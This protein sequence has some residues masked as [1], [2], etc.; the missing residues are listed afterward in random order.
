VEVGMMGVG[1]PGFPKRDAQAE[2]PIPRIRIN[3]VA[4]KR[5]FEDIGRNYTNENPPPL[6]L[7]K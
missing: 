4:M 1:V 5:G 6:P 7:S 3:C 2:R